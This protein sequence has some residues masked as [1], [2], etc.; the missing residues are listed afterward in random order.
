MNNP[1]KRMRE[2]SGRKAVANS[3]GHLV[4]QALEGSPDRQKAYDQLRAT[5]LKDNYRKVFP[6]SII[7]VERRTVGAPDSREREFRFAINSGSIRL[8]RNLWFAHQFFSRPR[9]VVIFFT[10]TKPKDRA[11]MCRRRF[12]ELK[13][14]ANTYDTWVTAAGRISGEMQKFDPLRVDLLTASQDSNG[15]ANSTPSAVSPPGSAAVADLIREVE[16]RASYQA[17]NPDDACEKALYFLALGRPDIGETIAREVLAENPEHAVALY[18]N[19]VLLLDASDRHRRQ[20]FTHDVMHQHGLAPVEAEEQW[21]VDR[22]AEESLQA[23]EKASVAFLLI[24]KARANWPARFGIKCYDLSPSMW[25]HRVDE[26]LFIQAASRIGSDPSRLNLPSNADAESALKTLSTIVA[27]IW[28]KGGKSI[29]W[30][31]RADFLRH[32]IIVAAQVDPDVARGCLKMLES[33]LEKRQPGQQELFWHELGIVL[34]VSPEPTLA[35]KLIP[36]VTDSCFC[37]ALFAVKPSSDGAALLRRIM[38]IGQ[39]DE[40][41]HRIA[42][43][44]LTVRSAVL[45]LER[46]NVLTEALAIC[47]GM[48]DRTDWPDTELGRK[49]RA[50]WRYETV[51]LLFKAS[52]V[53]FETNILPT[54]ARHASQALERATDWLE[55]I[56]GDKPLFKFI[57]SDEDSD[58][59]IVGNL[60][61]KEPNVVTDAQPSDLFPLHDERNHFQARRNPCWDKFAKW[62]ARDGSKLIPVLLAYALWLTEEHGQQ[63]ILEENCVKFSARLDALRR[64]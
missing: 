14:L 15:T 58:W 30:P 23:W 48:A 34:P 2:K 46:N 13:S 35:E 45:N 8:L 52:R 33:T 17:G 10:T 9:D 49:L 54:A 18:T 40:R 19:A 3:F 22:H 26:W 47:Q 53:A 43:H 31:T 36:A 50:C 41:N 29:L 61:H 42:A 60:L 38:G 56:A 59:E 62:A 27:E 20:A 63:E 11:E 28:S 4:S 6:A 21:H 5:Y 39:D 57:E 7:G 25:Q 44:S 32:F 51:L 64:G 55:S 16:Q 37:R 24:L 12:E 1:G